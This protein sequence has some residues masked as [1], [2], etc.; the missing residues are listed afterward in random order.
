MPPDSHQRGIFHMHRLEGMIVVVAVDLQIFRRHERNIEF[1]VAM[2]QAQRLGPKPRSMM[3]EHVDGGTGC[4]STRLRIVISADYPVGPFN[5]SLITGE[6]RQPMPLNGP[7][8]TVS[9]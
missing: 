8:A 7:I 5:A 9:L 3:K 4:K 6:V 1:E 2:Q